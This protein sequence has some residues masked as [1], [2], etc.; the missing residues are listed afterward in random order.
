MLRMMSYKE[1]NQILGSSLTPNHRCIAK[2]TALENDAQAEP[3]APFEYNRLVPVTAVKKKTVTFH[4]VLLDE[5]GN[6]IP[7]YDMQLEQGAT[8][9]YPEHPEKEG[10]KADGWDPKL[11]A[12]AQSDG[13]YKMKYKPEEDDS[14]GRENVAYTMDNQYQQYAPL[15]PTPTSII[16]RWAPAGGHWWYGPMD[17]ESDDKYGKDN[18][19]SAK[20]IAGRNFVT[21]GSTKYF[22]YSTLSDGCVYEY[23][24]P[25][26]GTI[27]DYGQS[28]TAGD[29][30]TDW[31]C[32]CYD[33]NNNYMGDYT[34]H[35]D[36][37]WVKFAVIPAG[38]LIND[39]MPPFAVVYYV[40]ENDGNVR[41]G[42][43]TATTPG[44][45][46]HYDANYGHK[47]KPYI[48]SAPTYFYQLGVND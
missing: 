11:P 30:M 13:T 43:V 21:L 15:K 33:E 26:A 36:C 8:I 24:R 35:S 44:G 23:A 14:P 18:G 10:W 45:I 20:T 9:P 5:D 1:A 47:G 19:I 29:L 31:S 22:T 25:T 32:P 6:V 40:A 34:I 3:L 7:G 2:R 28:I 37:D 16:S 38:Y 42:S 46:S 4:I 27:L 48:Q 41:K 39:I 12:T 17:G